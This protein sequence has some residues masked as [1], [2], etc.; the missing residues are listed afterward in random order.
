MA[1]LI[2]EIDSNKLRH[3]VQNDVTL[4]CAKFGKDLFDISKVIGRKTKWPRFLAYVPLFTRKPSQRYD[5]RAIAVHIWRPLAM[6]STTNQRWEHVGYNSVTIFI[7]FSV[8][9]SPICEIPRNFTK[10]RTYRSSR[11]SKITDLGVNRKRIYN[12]LLLINSNY[13]RISYRFQDIDKFSSKIACFF[14]LTPPLFDAV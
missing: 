3:D 2:S 12:F 14:Q 1:P 11:S 10:I 5:K 6:K 8:V 9:A 4:I 7:V 13:G